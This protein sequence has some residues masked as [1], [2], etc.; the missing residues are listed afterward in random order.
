MMNIITVLTIFLLFL[1]FLVINFAD[2]FFN[3]TFTPENWKQIP[4]Y[5]ENACFLRVKIHSKT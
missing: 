1:L 2:S 5:G 3:C 4:S